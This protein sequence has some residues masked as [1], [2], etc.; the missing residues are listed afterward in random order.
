MWDLSSLNRD[1]ALIPCSG[2]P[3]ILTTEPPGKFL[4]C[5]LNH[6]IYGWYTLDLPFCIITFRSSC[7]PPR[8]TE[9]GYVFK[10]WIPR[11][12]YLLGAEVLSQQIAISSCV[13]SPL[14]ETTQKA[15]SRNRDQE[16][17]PHLSLPTATAQGQTP[18]SS[19]GLFYLSPHWSSVSRFPH[20]HPLFGSGES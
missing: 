9:E 1:R 14:T 10:S 5:L 17:E 4:M 6:E 7:S 18:L 19:A 11:R 3:V 12:N 15:S 16:M 2:E 20:L 13:P 8:H